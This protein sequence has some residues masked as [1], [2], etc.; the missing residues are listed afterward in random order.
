MKAGINFNNEIF[1]DGIN[2]IIG[3]EFGGIELSG[4]QW[5]RLAIARGLY[6][7]CNFIILDE[8]TAAIDPIEESHLYN[9][10]LN[11]S[12]GKTSIIVT[13]RLGAVK[14]ADR[15]IVLS[16]GIIIEE[17]THEDLM[18]KNGK[19]KKMYESQSQWYKK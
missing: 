14:L 7:T 12:E 11:L 19:Y 13:H 9:N 1:N 10:F 8:P 17:G 4:G 18:K 16:N 2:T 5:Q 6:K 15:I 3:R